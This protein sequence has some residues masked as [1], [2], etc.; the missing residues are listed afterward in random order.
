MAMAAAVFSGLPASRAADPLPHTPQQLSE[1]RA[2][3]GRGADVFGARPQ[4][5]SATRPLT[6][7]QGIAPPPQAPALPFTYGGSGVVNGKAIVFLDQNHRSV[8]VAAGDIVDG[9]YRVEAVQRD[10]ALLR[11][12]PLDVVLVLPF[13]PAG[14][15]AQPAV[16][17]A[18]RV[19]RDPLFVSLPDELPFGQERP[20]ALGIA[21]GSAAARA[22]IEITYDANEVAV[23]GAKIMR[24]GK[25]VVEVNSQ[26]ATPAKPVH[27]KAIA[28]EAVQTEIGIA[29]IA[30]DAQGRSVEIR[31]MPSQ[32]IISLGN[33]N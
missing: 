17:A 7:V 23:S 27:L 31:G 15:V 28:E 29:A 16:P 2:Q 12:L 14:T 1:K 4:A 9:T 18:P 22:T 6:A 33:A 3:M 11:Y 30:F 10:R 21:P 20:L 26:T 5:P 13:G 19:A 24:P 25:A 8:M 32:H